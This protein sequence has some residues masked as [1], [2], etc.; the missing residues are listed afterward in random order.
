MIIAEINTVMYSY[1]KIT[2][3]IIKL[4]F[5]KKKLH[6]S[7]KSFKPALVDFWP[8]EDSAV[9]CKHNTGLLSPHKVHMVSVLA[10]SGIFT[11]QADMKQH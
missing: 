6:V 8:F 11:H 3:Q 5:R 9:N 10:N 7:V 1:A 2:H 4:M